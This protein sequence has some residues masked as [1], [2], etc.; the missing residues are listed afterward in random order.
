[1]T[2]GKNKH[3][4]TW[5]HSHTL[6][7]I[8][9]I[10]LAVKSRLLFEFLNLLC[11]LV[12]LISHFLSSVLLLSMQFGMSHSLKLTILMNEISSFFT[13][14]ASIHEKKSVVWMTQFL[15]LKYTKSLFWESRR[16]NIL[17]KILLA[18]EYHCVIP[19]TR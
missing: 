5:W 16:C 17:T 2:L 4:T 11:P 9:T 13:S 15:F 7:S 18:N 14:C 12:Y 3:W 10:T 19:L 8:T 1:M 6:L